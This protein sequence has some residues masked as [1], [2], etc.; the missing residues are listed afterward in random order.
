MAAGLVRSSI[1]ARAAPE[2]LATGGMDAMGLPAADLSIGG[3]R[4]AALGAE[5]VLELEVAIA[6][7]FSC[8]ELSFPH[9]TWRLG[10]EPNPSILARSLE[11]SPG[12]LRIYAVSLRGGLGSHYPYNPANCA[13][14]HAIMLFF[15]TLLAI[16]AESYCMSS[17]NHWATPQ[18]RDFIKFGAVA[19]AG[20]T[21]G[22]WAQRI[23]AAQQAGDKPKVAAIGVGGSRGAYSQGGAIAR[24][25]A[26]FGDM[27]AVCDVDD[28]HTAE[29][30]KD[31][32]GKLNMYRD[33][34]EML[35]TE[36]PDVVTI[37]TPDHWHVPIAIAAMRHGCDVYCEKPL[38]LTIDEGKRICEVVKET[39][40]VFQVGT[41]QRSQDESRF[42]KAI[43]MVHSGR[44]GNKEKVN[45][46]VAI[47][48]APTCEPIERQPVP[49]DLDWN[50]WVGPAAEAEYSHKRRKDFRWF[51]QYSGG[52]MT[53]WGAHHIDIAQ[54]ALGY[55]QS[56]PVK[57]SGQGTFPSIV[58][59]N[60]NWPD[61]FNGDQS[62][63]LCLQYRRRLSYRSDLCQTVK[64]SA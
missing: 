61:F 51:F 56:G 62:A 47:G 52:K 9:S 39:G 49:D 2:L 4:G 63:A 59:A 17:S 46:Y 13:I 57:I 33:Y 18:R 19:T 1:A 8:I 26:K 54:W 11:A 20:L 31:F 50:M 42:L 37:G 6:N 23:A 32:G 45:A 60:F 3:G 53:D 29:F 21:H 12:W 16:Q 30:N 22:V 41:Q 34:R 36:K 5:G 55:D 58:P 35:G 24:R 44:L 64:R 14:I 43:A 10:Q 38:T 28:L 40:C 27:I 48:G 7:R 25:A 15:S